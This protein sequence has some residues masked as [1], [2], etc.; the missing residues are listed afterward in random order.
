MVNA[1]KILYINIEIIILKVVINKIK[2]V[3]DFNLINIF[4]K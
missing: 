1:I 3:D 2:E 4:I